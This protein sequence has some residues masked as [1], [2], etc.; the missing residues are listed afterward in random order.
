[1]GR[2]DPG[3]VLRVGHILDVEV[4]PARLSV[5]FALIVDL[6]ST[7]IPG[8]QAER[9]EVHREMAQVLD[10][11]P[12]EFDQAFA[13]TTHARFRG[14]YGDLPSTLRAMAHRCGG[15]PTDNQLRQATDLRRKLA[16]QLLGAAPVA[17]LD[18][19]TE[20][21]AAGWRTGLVSNITAETVRQWP[22]SALAQYFE[23]T[24]FSCEVGA[25]RPDLC[26][27]TSVV[28]ARVANP[29]Q[30]DVSR[31]RRPVE[32]GNPA[33]GQAVCPTG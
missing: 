10:V 2:V 23:T 12:D 26:A 5:V 22:E 31:R 19:L 16:Q 33:Y 29:A 15:D 20:L 27:S 18:A 7:L 8:G 9:A 6:F 13:A 24:A 3:D 14:A 32:P 1:M 25:L 30:S 28:V 11:D 4:G 17:T 21:R